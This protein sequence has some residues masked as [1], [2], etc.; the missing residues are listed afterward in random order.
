MENMRSTRTYRDGDEEG[1]FNLIKAVYPS[2]PWNRDQWMRFWHWM[3]QENPAGPAK[4]YLVEEQGKIV[5]HRAHILVDL[6][7]GNEIMKACQNIDFM[8]HPDSKYRGL[9]LLERRALREAEEEG[10]HISFGFPTVAA[11]PGFMKAGYFEIAFMRPMIKFFNLKNVVQTRIHNKYLAKLCA[12]TASPLLRTI[13]RART[14][15]AIEGLKITQVPS[16]DDRVNELWAK[17]SDSHQIIRV[18][19]KQYLDWRYGAP[20]VEYTIY[21][22]E[23]GEV[24]LGYIVLRCAQLDTFKQGR[25][26]DIVGYTEEIIHCLVSKAVEHFR[27]EGADCVYCNM[28]A[29]E[30]H[31]RALK[32]NGF[33]SA[34]FTKRSWFGAY[35]SAP[36]IPKAS[37]EDYRNWFIQLGDSDLI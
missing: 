26:Y 3:Y 34:P 29:N 5:A 17:V 28:L 13:Y 10:L 33:I 18:R 24:V 16:F 37:V 1:I 12:V 2:M 14:S 4:I 30:T 25:I 11:R 6:K 9:F 31:F 32:N 22:A 7:V 8:V 19:S 21:L 35:S 27:K 15:P 20:D 23:K 36:S